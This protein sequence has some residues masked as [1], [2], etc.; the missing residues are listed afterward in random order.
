MFGGDGLAQVGSK[1]GN[2]ALARQ[3]VADK[4]NAFD[5]GIVKTQCHGD[6]SLL[7]IAPGVPNYSPA[8]KRK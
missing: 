7:V 6:F 5:R 8:Q 1:R 2:T 4:R 3:I